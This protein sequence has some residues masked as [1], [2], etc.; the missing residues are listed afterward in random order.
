MYCEFLN[1]FQTLDTS[2]D[3]KFLINFSFSNV[4]VKNMFM[5]YEEND[6]SVLLKLN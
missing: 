5:K 4:P 1:Y 6:L 3:P 2:E